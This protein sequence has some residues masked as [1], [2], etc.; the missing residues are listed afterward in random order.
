[1]WHG[2]GRFL[3]VKGIWRCQHQALSCCPQESPPSWSPGTALAAALPVSFIYLFCTNRLAA[4]SFS[5]GLKARREA[6]KN[7]DTLPGSLPFWSRVLQAGGGPW[8]GVA[9]EATEGETWGPAMPKEWDGGCCPPTGCRPLAPPVSAPL[10]QCWFGGT[11][12]QGLG[13]LTPPWEEER[14]DLSIY[15]S[16]SFSSDSGGYAPQE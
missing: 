4:D 15:L 7:R 12:V 11:P 14:G 1:M 16:I 3:G 2:I 5:A 10:S 8:Q 13:T 9:T 6:K